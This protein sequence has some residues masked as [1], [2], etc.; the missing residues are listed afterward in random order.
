[1]TETV[2]T[3]SFVKKL[4]QGQKQ[5]HTGKK[6]H[7]LTNLDSTTLVQKVPT[8]PLE[9]I[10]K[11]RKIVEGNVRDF[12]ASPFWI[13]I[14]NDH[15]W[16][17][18]IVAG[19]QV[20]KSTYCTDML[21]YGATVKPYQQVCYVTHDQEA[22]TAVSNQRLRIGT[23]E[24]NPILKAYPIHGT[25]SV[26]KVELKNKS[27]I[28]MK[29]DA[30]Q[31]R[32]VE[33]LTL[34]WCILDEAQYQDIEFL[35]KLEKTFAKSKGRLRVLG[36]GGEQGS[37]YERMWR[38][39]D[40]REWLYDDGKK[41]Q[42]F[43]NMSWRKKLRFDGVK[44][45]KV[46]NGEFKDESTNLIIGDYM[47]EILNGH[48]RSTH[49]ENT[50]FHGYH[51]SQLINGFVPITKEDAR[52]KYGIPIKFSVEFQIENDPQSIVTT[53]VHG[54]FNKAMRRPITPDDV[55]ACMRPY[56]H[57]RMMDPEDVIALKA[58]YGDDLA[59]TMGIDWGSG[60]S[61]SVCAMCILL[62]W[63][64]YQIY[65]IAHIEA[66][67][68]EDQRNQPKYFVGKFLAYECDL[69]VADL[70]YGVDKV[71]FMQDGGHDI[72]TGAAYAGLGI[73]RFLGAR[74]TSSEAKP[75]QF[76]EQVEDEHGDSVSR[77]TLDKTAIIQEFIDMI[78]TKVEHPAS[79]P[80]PA[81][82]RPQLIIPFAD[83]TRVLGH[84][85]DLVKDFTDTTRKDVALI[86]DVAITDPR[87]HPRKEFNHPKDTMMAII[88][89]RQASNRF[90]DSKWI[91]I[92]N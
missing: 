87:Q 45:E 80:L 74:T 71:K 54:E 59:V 61:A 76:H 10:Y 20:F 42:G 37:P 31:Y 25:G 40:Q 66:R 34:S 12:R 67:P 77:L 60:P 49:P 36:I 30:G 32:H 3:S 39:T 86:E 43:D 1:M 19:R 89:A 52:F 68:R 21:A 11:C 7:D 6:Q 24:D 23:F 26:L 62:F 73:D 29:T 4:K 85:I 51:I 28:Y 91:V 5:A 33:G 50:E 84:P 22:L 78:I 72:E 88:Y 9:W 47:K 8:D 65:Q 69:G 14:Y 35:A 75:F 79:G 17:L 48:W 56:K 41:Y 63:K 70:G 27:V 18:M 55:Y 90:K 53:H 92:S 44:G 2:K 15:H 83:E 82:P 38:R 64:K 46:H 57:L 16:D 81:E 13:D 58:Q